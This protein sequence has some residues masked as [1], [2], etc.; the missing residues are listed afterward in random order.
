M[1]WRKLLGAVVGVAATAGASAI[2]P[3][4]GPVVGGAL[5]GG[6]GTKEVGKQVQK[7]TGAAVHK[8]AGPVMASLGALGGAQFVDPQTLCEAVSQVCANPVFV[9]G[10]IGLFMVGLHQFYSGVQRSGRK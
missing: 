3:A 10:G 7:R 9:S 2:N 1:K 6:A 5:L 4:L 8:G